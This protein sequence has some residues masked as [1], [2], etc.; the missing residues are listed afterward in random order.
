MAV[1]RKGGDFAVRA[2]VSS[3]TGRIM[4]LAVKVVKYLYN[5]H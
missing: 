5:L 4:R 1:S 2:W 3:P